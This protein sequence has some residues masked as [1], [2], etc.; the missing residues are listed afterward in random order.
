ME[1]TKKT[2][3]LF[4]PDLHKRLMKLASQKGVS[5]GQLIRSA[6]EQQYWMVSRDDRISAA[7]T[8]SALSLPVAS[9]RKMKL[10]S[11]P[12]PKELSK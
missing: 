4:P 1:L 11:T 12:R 6:C 7:R 8:L 2:T 10:E 5:M 3:V 9:P